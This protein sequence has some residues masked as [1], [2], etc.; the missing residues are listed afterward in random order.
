M[1]GAVLAKADGIVVMTP[2]TYALPSGLTKVANVAS[3]VNLY[4]G[5]ALV[6]MNK[7]TYDKLPKEQQEAL[8]RAGARNPAAKMRAEV[9]GF[10]ET[11]WGMMEKSGGQISKPTPEQRAAWRKATEPVYAQ[12]VK[13]TGG[14][15]GAFFAAMEAGRKACAK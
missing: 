6:L 12:I 5:P 1:G 4:D 11:L 7:A 10:E 9:R 13:E 14:E 8:V 15:A 2:I 3:R